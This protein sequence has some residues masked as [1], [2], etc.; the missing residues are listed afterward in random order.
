MNNEIRQTETEPIKG[1]QTS[2]EP[3]ATFPFGHNAV[4]VSG[5]LVQY[6]D[7][8]DRNRKLGVVHPLLASVSQVIPLSSFD[9]STR[10]GKI[11]AYNAANVEGYSIADVLDAEIELQ[12]YFLYVVTMPDEQTGLPK[13]IIRSALIDAEGTVYGAASDGV[14]RA[15]Q[16]LSTLFG[17]A[18]WTPPLIVIPRERKS[19]GTGRR[20]YTLEI[21]K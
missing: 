6:D 16:G 5:S 4:P 13:E 21:V 7:A 20:F 14:V 15:L 10:E 17:L 19:K 8:R 1:N 11:R 9:L 12:H 3:E 18:P 2:D